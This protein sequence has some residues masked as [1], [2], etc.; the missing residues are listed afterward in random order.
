MS[1]AI[2]PPRKRIVYPETDGLPMAENT[3]Q[4]RWIVLVKDNLEAIF[5]DQDDVFVAGDHFWYPV[6]G[7]PGIRVAPDIMV[8]FGR[9]KGD[10]RS[11]LQWEEGGVAPQVVWEILSP[12]NRHGEMVAKFQFYEHYGVEEY[13]VYDPDTGEVSGWIRRNGRLEPI[14]DMNGW[15]SPL[16]QVRFIKEGDELK[17]YGPDGKAFQTFQEVLDQAE[18]AQ[19]HAEQAQRQ[20]EQ[21]RHQAE[22]AK[23]Q[24]EEQAQLIQQLREKLQAQGTPPDA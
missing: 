13:Y 6:E 22:Q 7:Q 5:A 18:Q 16:L 17:L 8:A 12:G 19:Q 2:L 1:S 21:A 3:V 23:R 20:A 15:I 11:Y 14:A 9:P 4:F 10:R 24:I